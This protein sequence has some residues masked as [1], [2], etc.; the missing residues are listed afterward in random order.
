MAT[1]VGGMWKAKFIEFRKTYLERE[2]TNIKLQK[3]MYKDS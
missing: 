2:R 3:Y 1:E